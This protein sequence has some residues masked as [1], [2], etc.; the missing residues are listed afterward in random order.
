MA[1]NYVLGTK[2]QIFEKDKSMIYR[3]DRIKNADSF[4]LRDEDNNKRIVSKDTLL[5]DFVEILPDAFLNIMITDL[6]QYP[7]LYVCVNKASDLSIGNNKP[8]IILRQRIYSSENA[9]NTG[10]FSS[11]VLGD[12]ICVATNS[13]YDEIDKI[14]E[15]DN[16][17]DSYSY[18]IYLDDTTDSIVNT[19]SM[20]CKSRI[21]DVLASIKAVCSKS[22]KDS[23]IEFFGVES[24]IS[25]L[26]KEHNFIQAFRAIFN[27]NYIN[28][29]IDAS[30][31]SEDG[32][33][34]LSD[35]VKKCIEDTIRKYISNIIV[36][37]YA[38]D[39]DIS[40]IVRYKHIVISDVTEKIYFIAY[41][42]DGDYPV[43]DDI[44][45]AMNNTFL[46]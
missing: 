1:K 31:K 8:A 45:K 20:K 10:S 29:E 33:I 3:L 15:F 5:N 25:D 44:L 30:N 14:F 42:E 4:V 6:D 41:N 36:L 46:H 12:T 11:F 39:I 37:E 9:Y 21:A 16:I 17:D 34:I 32:N 38:K 18:A 40:K 23:G 7:D 43:D 28:T 13:T 27:I 24:N 2:F 26:M 19:L 35:N 22:T